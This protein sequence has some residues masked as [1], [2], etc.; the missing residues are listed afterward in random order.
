MP[1]RNVLIITVVLLL[2][3]ICYSKIPHNQYV[4]VYQRAA[5]MLDAR[6]VEEIDQQ[7]LFQGAMNGMMAT[8]DE[9]SVY[10]APLEYQ[11]LDEVLNQE[12]GGLGIYIERIEDT[13]EIRI[14]TPALNSPALKVGIQAGDVIVQIDG[15]RSADLTVAESQ[16]MMKGPP[17]EMVNLMIRRTGEDALVPFSVTREL[18][19]LL[20][21]LGYDRKEDGHWKYRLPQENQ[22]MVYLQSTDFAAH[23]AEEIASIL[24]EEKAA[25]G[26]RGI[27][28]DLRGNGGGL[29]STAVALC[30]LFIDQQKIVDVRFRNSQQNKSFFGT[31]EATLDATTP[32]VVLIDRLSA[33]ASEIAAAC[34][35]DSGRAVVIGERSYGKGSVQDV[36]VLEA[37]DEDHAIKFTIAHFLR[38][39]G[40]NIHRRKPLDQANPEDAWG[41]KPTQGYEV[42]LND[43]ELE[44][45]QQDKLRRFI[46]HP[47]ESP[48]IS[49]QQDQA[50]TTVEFGNENP[51]P[52]L[53]PQ[54]RKA[55]EYLKQR[56]FSPNAGDSN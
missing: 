8:L 34:L 47:R 32:M 25:N 55:V 50:P 56:N 52:Y 14:V 26:Y 30:D 22:G 21:V 16:K 42:I 40:K 35:Q 12:F 24:K 23:S 17:G 20:S 15:R 3:L 33:S 1:K 29:L 11:G 38:P 28:L 54:L 51:P 31:V 2:C 5:A 49:E 6:Y 46:I 53:D 37:G 19:Q 43:E 18:V 48:S 36:E 9:H 27:I 4:R 10:M 39:N 7:Q 13:N 45:Y 44:A 41:V